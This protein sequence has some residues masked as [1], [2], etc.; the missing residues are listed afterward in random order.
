MPIDFSITPA[1]KELQQSARRFAHQVLRGV[2]PAIRHLPTADERFQA[3]RPFYEALVQAGFM[4]R[5]VPAPFGGDGQGMVEMAVITE[6]FHAVDVNVSLTALANLL[7]L[8]PLLIAGDAELQARCLAPFLSPSG[9]PLAGFASSEPGGSANFAS[10]AP[11]E[12]VRTVARR[13]GE[14]WI[15]DGAKQWV[16]SATG[17]DGRGADVLCLVCRTDPQA[18]PAQALSVLA[19]ERPTGGWGADCFRHEHSFD[20]LG[21]RGHLTPRFSLQGLRIPAGNLIGPQGGG[22]ALVEASFSG[23]AALV[24]VMALAL[25]RAAFDFALNFART[26]KCGGVLPILEHQAVG[27]A[28]ADAKMAMEAVRSLSYRACQAQDIQAPGAHELSLQAKVFGSE[29]AVRVITEL[30]RVVGVNSYDHA[31]PLAG[32]LQDALALPI[33]DGGNMGIRRRQLHDMMRAPGYDPL[34]ASGGA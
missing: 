6:E 29:T 14:H 16:S 12:G 18:E 11:G 32:W 31:L 27:Y 22:Q 5:L 25:M 10:P 26:E 17:W 4:R 15:V 33:F 7:G 13:E 20:T 19:A 28:L 1:Q 21:H 24:G 8:T 2:A 30:M 34:G 23:T 3:T 9:A